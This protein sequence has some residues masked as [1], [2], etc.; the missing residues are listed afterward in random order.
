MRPRLALP[1]GMLI[2]G[3]AS[4][5]GQTKLTTRLAPVVAATVT[6]P[7]LG[8]TG[9]LAGVTINLGYAGI[10]LGAG[11]YVDLIAPTSV[12]LASS[13]TV[14]A[15]GAVPNGSYSVRFDF[16]NVGAATAL[17]YSGPSGAAL[18]SCFLNAGAGYTNV[19]SCA[20]PLSIGD[21]RLTVSIQPTSGVSMTLK[22][23]TVTR[24]Q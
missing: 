1:L 13:A 4:L 2:L 14:S 9:S 5:Q 11:G 20:L 22:Q 18:G 6:I 23:V 16:V 24:Y 8:L 19:Q 3:P 15:A 21:G 7:A 17:R 10:N 12:T